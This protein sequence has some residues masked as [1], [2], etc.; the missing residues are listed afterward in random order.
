MHVLYILQS[1]INKKLYIGVTSDLKKRLKQHNQGENK[2]TKSGAPYQV[3]Y[4]EAYRD[5][6]DALSRE[7][8]LKQFGKAYS[9]LKKRISG[10][11]D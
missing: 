5:K 3:V 4:C 1:E 2:S 6:K 10:S 11:L 8:K 9:E 7:R